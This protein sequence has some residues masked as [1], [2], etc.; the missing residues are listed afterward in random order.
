MNE[1]IRLEFVDYDEHRAGLMLTVARRFATA[2]IHGRTGL[3]RGWVYAF[4]PPDAPYSG[5]DR[6][7]CVA[8]WT[9]ARVVV[10]RENERSTP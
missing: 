3:R 2:N 4:G 9:P 7:S 8:Y 6:W 5:P 10:V 1:R